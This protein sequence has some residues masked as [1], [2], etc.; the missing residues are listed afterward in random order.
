MALAAA[1]LDIVRRLVHE[2]AAIVLDET[3][4]YLVEAR[5]TP[6]CPAEGF[7]NVPALIAALRARPAPDLAAKVVDAMTTNETSFFRDSHPFESIRKEILPD[8]LARRAATRSLS[9]WCAACSTGQEPYSIAMMLRDH[10]PQTAGWNISILAT[11]ISTR[12]LAR[13]RDGVF[14]QLEINRG[15]PAPLL[16]KHFTK[17][18]RDWR[19]KDE[20]KSMIRF[21]EM[22]LATAWPPV[23]RVDLLLMRN[24]LIYFDDAT[25]RTITLRA[26]KV[27]ADDGYFMLGSAELVAADIGFTRAVLN[28]RTPVYRPVAA[29]APGPAAQVVTVA[30]DIRG[31]P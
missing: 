27:L 19:L 9:V 22:N 12:A 25:K 28:D 1:D 10:F 3:K 8:L 6:L 5:L 17:S 31:K 29:A 16:V 23:G 15:L 2:R 14:N 20:V 4:G 26:R 7:A 24:V 13:A 18:G 30:S 21:R 11:D